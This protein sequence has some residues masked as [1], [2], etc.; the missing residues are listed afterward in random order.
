MAAWAARA[1]GRR[2]A[3]AGLPRV[4]LFAA[5]AVW[6]TIGGPTTGTAAGEGVIYASAWQVDSFG[7]LGTRFRQSLA[8]KFDFALA[9]AD[10]DRDVMERIAADPRNVGFVQRDVYV[11]YLRDHAESETRF[12]FYGDIPACL[13]A[14][15][16]KGSAIQAYGDLVRARAD[17][18]V[19]LDVGP[20]SGRVAATFENMR[21]LDEPLAHLELEHRGGS[22]ALSRVMSGETDA[23][24]F[25]IYGPFASGLVSDTIKTDAVD[26]V[27]FFS[28]AIVIGSSSRKLP[29]MLRQIKLGDSGWFSSGHPYHTTCTTLGVVVNARTDARLSEAVAQVLLEGDLAGSNRPWYA[30]VGERFVDAIGAARK[31]ALGAG[32][33]VAAWVDATYGAPANE[34]VAGAPSAAPQLHPAAHEGGAAEGA[35]QPAGGPAPAVP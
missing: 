4:A 16:R 18:P 20:A 29:Y 2:G 32:A 24:L 14:V 28:E 5:F 23:A 33:V 25:L 35:A 7:E 27:P 22:R 3:A 34:T 8:G 13:V 30:A 11:Q 21:R 6:G 31:M 19:T 26:L 10:A 15:V 9:T 1:G 12:E 17:R